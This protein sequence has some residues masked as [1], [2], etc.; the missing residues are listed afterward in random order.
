[1]V[2]AFIFVGWIRPRLAMIRASGG[3]SKRARISLRSRGEGSRAVAPNATTEILSTWSGNRLRTCSTHQGECTTTAAAC[4]EDPAVEVEPPLDAGRRHPAR[5]FGAG[6]ERA[7]GLVGPRPA[8]RLELATDVG[9][10]VHPGLLGIREVEAGEAQVVQGHDPRV[11]QQGVV[12]VAVVVR[13]PHLVDQGVVA[14]DPG[15]PLEQPVVVAAE[16]G[17][18]VGRCAAG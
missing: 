4:C 5:S 12:H 8:E 3:I 16:L 11:A 1:M 13:V 9:V 14:Q 10:P 15:V 7:E 6:G 18:F 2:S 17:G